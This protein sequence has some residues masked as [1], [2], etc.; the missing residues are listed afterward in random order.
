MCSFSSQSRQSN[1]P[2]ASLRF[3]PYRSA[4]LKLVLL[5]SALHKL[6]NARFAPLKLAYCKLANISP[7]A[8][9]RLAPHRSIACR[10]TEAPVG[11]GPGAILWGSGLL[12]HD[13]SFTTEHTHSCFFRTRG[14][15]A[16]CTSFGA[17]PL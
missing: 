3:A 5:R 6:A 15:C 4:P 1:L 12:F 7:S 9:Y 16:P 11:A 13:K 17:V 2:F 8:P 10:S 14:S